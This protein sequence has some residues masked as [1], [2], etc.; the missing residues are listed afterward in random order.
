MQVWKVK[1]EE[2]R[3]R[4][5]LSSHRVS[6]SLQMQDR[7]FFFFQQFFGGVKISWQHSGHMQT[8]KQKGIVPP[9]TP[10]LAPQTL[11]IHGFLGS[12]S[13]LV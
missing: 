11:L 7:F 8:T 1:Q 6:L 9:D 12:G 3:L 13:P 2:H 5:L 4:K 10:K